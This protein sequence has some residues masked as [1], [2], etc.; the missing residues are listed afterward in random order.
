MEGEAVLA[1]LTS[2]PAALG[3]LVQ[4]RSYIA[5]QSFLDRTYSKDARNY[6]GATNYAAISDDLIR[7][8]VDLTRVLPT[9][10]SDILFIAQGGAIEDVPVDQGQGAL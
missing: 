10:E 4:R 2:H 1:P 5:A 3:G 8:A 6:W 7:E 9:A